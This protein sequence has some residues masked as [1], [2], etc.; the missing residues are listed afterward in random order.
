[1]RTYVVR[2]FL[3]SVVVGGLHRAARADEP[4]T[5]DEATFV[6]RVAAATPALA[7]ADADVAI[8]RA[9]VIAAGVR[10]RPSLSIEREEVFAAGT[11]LPEHTLRLDWPVEI[12]GRRGHHLDAARLAVS[13]VEAD[14]R[15]THHDVLAAALVAFDAA[16]AA[17]AVVD[18]LRQARIEL[19]R[20]VDVVRSRAGAGDAAGYDLRR[21]EVELGMFDADLG[22]AEADLAA[23]RLDL[24]A[25]VGE[26]GTPFD[27]GT[28][29]ASP[30]AQIATRSDIVAAGMRVRSATA[31]ATAARRTWLS[32]IT[33]SV[34]VRTADL[35][36]ETAWGY[37]AG[38]SLDLP[39]S[40]PHA[41]ERVRSIGEAARWRAYQT[42]IEV[43]AT[44]AIARARTE[45]E[46]RH[47][48]QAT[49]AAGPLATIAALV[50]QAELAYR[51]GDRPIGELLDVHRVAREV[52][53]QAVAIDAA[54]RR[55]TRSLTAATTELALP[56]RSTP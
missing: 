47:A 33:F 2:L 43:E 52:R 16:A 6:A 41:A 24:G 45:L 1:M 46:R 44:A 50:P 7:L 20:V 4:A 42:A 29:A 36:S 17:R 31:M 56:A 53:L 30:P 19:V 38:I 14:G 25:L 8:E 28:A 23:R 37:V 18:V 55:A 51:E 40:D 27:A 49:H 13:A 54:V 48:Q 26:P 39:T 3:L 15:R 21:L 22:D 34:G 10:P 11:A 35:G 32:Q 9:G 12:G 5:L